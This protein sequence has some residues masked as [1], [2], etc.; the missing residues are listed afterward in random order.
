MC[1]KVCCTSSS[2]FLFCNVPWM[3]KYW[4]RMKGGTP[5]CIIVTIPKAHLILALYVRLEERDDINTPALRVLKQESK[6]TPI[7]AYS[8]PFYVLPKEYL[9]QRNSAHRCLN[10]LLHRASCI[11][12]VHLPSVALHFQISHFAVRAHAQGQS[13]SNYINAHVQ[14]CIHE[15]AG[16]I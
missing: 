14:V 8:P 15:Q 3:W 11:A 5:S 10:R 1:V 13:L 16:L 2:L 7:R 6:T 9:R 4:V 12:V